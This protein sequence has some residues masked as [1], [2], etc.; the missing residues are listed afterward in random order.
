MCRTDIRHCRQTRASLPGNL[1]VPARSFALTTYVMQL[2]RVRVRCSRSFSS[3]CCTC[4]DPFARPGNQAVRQAL[5][6]TTT[7]T[8]TTSTW[9]CKNLLKTSSHQFWPLIERSLHN[10][11][12]SR[13]APAARCI[14]GHVWCLLT[15]LRSTA[16]RI[17]GCHSSSSVNRICTCA[18]LECSSVREGVVCAYVQTKAHT[19]SYWPALH[20]RRVCAVG[21]NTEH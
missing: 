8:T 11:S 2:G 13:S 4:A 19:L 15:L 12:N 16:V 5:A 3:L 14:V 10:E 20:N 17:N 7:I 6:P 21:R 1:G 9:Q 18:M